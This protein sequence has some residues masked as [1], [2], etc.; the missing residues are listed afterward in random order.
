[1]DAQTPSIAYQSNLKKVRKTIIILSRG[2]FR[3]EK[4]TPWTFMYKIM[5]PSGEKEELCL[6]HRGLSTARAPRA[7][8]NPSLAFDWGG[9]RHYSDE[10]PGTLTANSAPTWLFL[11]HF[12]RHLQKF[13]KND[14]KWRHLVG[15]STRN[16]ILRKEDIRKKQALRCRLTSSSPPACLPRHPRIIGR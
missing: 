10:N 2:C 12:D 16:E 14:Q 13:G 15:F 4:N 3:Q 8:M 7:R 9:R 6:T 11:R 5:R 1:M